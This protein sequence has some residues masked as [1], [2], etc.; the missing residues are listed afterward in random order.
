MG[1][2][3]THEQ[4]ALQA[5]GILL[6]AKGVGDKETV[7]RFKAMRPDAFPAGNLREQFL[8]LTNSKDLTLSLYARSG[9]IPKEGQKLFESVIEFI[10]AAGEAPDWADWERQ[11]RALGDTAPWEE[12]PEILLRHFG[13]SEPVCRGEGCG[14][15]QL[16]DNCLA[17]EAWLRL[18][19]DQQ[20]E[21][22]DSLRNFQKLVRAFP[23][24]VK[25]MLSPIIKQSIEEVCNS[26]G[27]RRFRGGNTRKVINK[28]S[29]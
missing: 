20:A 1:S 24:E 7:A 4:I 19:Q 5:L 21:Q 17:Y 3:L 26:L 9:I 13:L 23:H 22:V 6:H 28:E 12:E 8:A 16:C 15:G 11:V 25:E 10:T 18:I 29:A 2:P 14:P 27:D